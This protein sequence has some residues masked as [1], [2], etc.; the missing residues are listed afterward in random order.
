MPSYKA[1]LKYYEN[2]SD[3][4]KKYFSDLPALVEKFQNQIALAYMFFKVEQAQNKVLYCGVVKLH[5]ANS[6]ITSNVINKHHLTRDGFQALFKKIFGHKMSEDTLS[7]IQSAEKIRDQVIHGKI[8][9]DSDIRKAIAEVLDYAKLLNS[10][11]E[12]TAGFKPFGDLRGFKGRGEPLDKS[13][14]KWLLKGMEFS[15]GV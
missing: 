3:E 12:K 4:I 6:E 10:E 15:V 2:C 1:V 8:V 9:T 11:M 14:T 7:K 13:T 5:R